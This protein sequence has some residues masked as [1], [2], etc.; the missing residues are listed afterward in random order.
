MSAVAKISLAC[1]NIANWYALAK[2]TS[3]YASLTNSTS[4][5]TELGSVIGKLS[6]EI[7]SIILRVVYC[8]K[9]LE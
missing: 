8:L 3:T 5:L 2:N 6:S 4:A 7:F 1:S 9:K